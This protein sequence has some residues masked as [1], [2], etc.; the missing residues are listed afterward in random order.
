MKHGFFFTTIFFSIRLRVRQS[1][2]DG[3]QGKDLTRI[4]YLLKAQSK[5]LKKHLFAGLLG[6]KLRVTVG[7]VGT[8]NE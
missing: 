4:T 5:R 6:V 2:I 1:G 8:K 3:P 7:G